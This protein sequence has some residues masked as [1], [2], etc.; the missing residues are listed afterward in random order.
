MILF[1]RNLQQKEKEKGIIEMN[2]KKSASTSF[3]KGIIIALAVLLAVPTGLVIY[4]ASALNEAK[5][6][7]QQA[8]SSLET[9]ETKLKETETKLQETESKLQEQKNLAESLNA[10]LQKK[11]DIAEG[12]VKGESPYAM[13][14]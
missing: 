4:G 8:E 6:G 11:V 10:E 12:R 3:L 1:A 13:I 14:A 9:A 2:E 7:L 5:A